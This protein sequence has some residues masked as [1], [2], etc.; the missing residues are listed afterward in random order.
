MHD[1][2]RGGPDR[3]SVELCNLESGSNQGQLI[4]LLADSE[5]GGIFCQDSATCTDDRTSV[6]SAQIQFE[7][8]ASCELTQIGPRGLGL[9]LDIV[10]LQ[11]KFSGQ[12]LRPLDYLFEGG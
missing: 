5:C 9:D 11:F 8:T 1:S 12:F 3:V 6:T 2:G 7:L 4:L 10:E